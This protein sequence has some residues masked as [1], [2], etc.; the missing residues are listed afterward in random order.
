M[1]EV[2]EVTGVDLTK[3]EKAEKEAR[4]KAEKEA[5]EKWEKEPAQSDFGLIKK[6][7]LKSLSDSSTWIV[8]EIVY[9]GPGGPVAVPCTRGEQKAEYGDLI[10]RTLIPGPTPE[11]DITIIDLVPHEV[12]PDEEPVT[13]ISN[14]D[15]QKFLE[16]KAKKI[17]E[18]RAKV[19]GGKDMLPEHK[20]APSLPPR[21]TQLPATGNPAPKR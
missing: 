13:A 5:R 21:P 16:D 1:T 2:A 11:E 18:I 7:E 12:I 14:K 17:K 8:E 4:E 6:V 19:Q 3:Q 20:P 15:Y 9:Q 10:V